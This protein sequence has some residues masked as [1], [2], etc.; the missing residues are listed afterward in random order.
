MSGTENSAKETVQKP[1]VVALPGELGYRLVGNAVVLALIF[2]L[3]FVTLLL[4]SD[5]VAR[6]ISEWKEEWFAYTADAGFT[7]DDI[8]ITG[9]DKTSRREIAEALNLQRGDNFL[10]INIYEIK[11]KTES[12]PWVRKAVIRRSFFPNVLQIDIEEKQVRALWQIR[13]RFHPVDF[14]GNV[15]DAPYKPS[16]PILLI[17]GEGA[18]QHINSLLKIVNSDEALAKRIKVANFISQRRWNLIFDDIKNGITVKLPERSVDEAWKKLVKLEKT[19][20]ILK[21]KLTIID[22]R[23]KNKVIFE[24]KRSDKS[25]SVKLKNIKETKG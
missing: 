3:G 23:L 10:K 22:L 24:L 17:V 11:K 9:R 5:I 20:G 13:E 7:L 8:V 2:L 6:Q 19:K 1:N 18:P 4:N 14:D 12:L 25:K 15:I 16:K 21:R